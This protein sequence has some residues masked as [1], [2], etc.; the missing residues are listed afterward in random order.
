MV[1]FVLIENLLLNMHED[2]LLIGGAP[3]TVEIIPA[4]VN[5]PRAQAKPRV[6]ILPGASRTTKKEE[7][8]V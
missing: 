7:P 6:I 1:F 2:T 4:Y 5:R 3:P 8:K